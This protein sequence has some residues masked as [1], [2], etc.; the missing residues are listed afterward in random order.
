MEQN[1]NAII[2]RVSFWFLLIQFAISEKLCDDHNN[3][4]KIIKKKKKKKLENW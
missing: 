1:A 4:M 3:K 2:F